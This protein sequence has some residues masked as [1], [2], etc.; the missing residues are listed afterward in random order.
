MELGR[1]GSGGSCG[2]GCSTLT[3][4]L[5]DLAEVIAGVGGGRS[6]TGLDT[7]LVTVNGLGL[8]GRD[9][10]NAHINEDYCR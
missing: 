5:E 10:L 6:G 2:G 1:G 3:G 7:D 9:N 8:L 4:L